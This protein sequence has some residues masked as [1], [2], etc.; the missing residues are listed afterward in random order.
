MRLS[1]WAG[2]PPRPG[3]TPT[4][5][6]RDLSRRLRSVRDIDLLAEAYNGSRFGR[7]ETD[8]AATERLSRLWAALRAALAW[9]VVRRL[10]RRS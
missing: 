9:E 1:S 3:Q 2:Q 6:A 7:K 4:D 5:F 8:A 10:W